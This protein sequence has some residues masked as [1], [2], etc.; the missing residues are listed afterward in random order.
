MNKSFYIKRIKIIN[1]KKILRILNL[2]GLT[3][4]FDRKLNIKM[5]NIKKKNNMLYYLLILQ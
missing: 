2:I 1:I 3:Q 4:L 5:F